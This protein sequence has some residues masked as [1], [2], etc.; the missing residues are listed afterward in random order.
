M[1]TVNESVARW[2]TQLLSLRGEERLPVLLELTWHLRQRDAERALQLAAEARALH[3]AH[4][5]LLAHSAIVRLD[6]VEA[7]LAWLRGELEAA[8]AAADQLLARFSALGDLAGQA[9][10]HWLLAWIA[11]DRGDH[12]RSLAEFV[13]TADCA[14]AAGDPLRTGIAQAANARWE[15][16]RDRVRAKANWGE[17]I[18]ASMAELHPSLA[19]WVYDYLALSASH[20]GDYGGAADA[21]VRCYESALETGQIRAAITAATNIGEDF[22]IVND[23]QSALEWMQC[24]LDLARPTGWPRSVGA[25]LMHTAD[26]LRRLGQFDA[27]HDML[28]E[29]LHVLQPLANARSYAIALQYMGDLKLAM[30]DCAGALAAFEQLEARGH[31]LD[32]ADFRSIAQRGKAQALSRL[33]RTAAALDAAQQAIDLADGQGHSNNHISALRAMASVHSEHPGLPTPPG[34][35]EPNAALHY[36]Q[37]ALAVSRGIDGYTVP[38]DLYDAMGVAYAQVGDYARAYEMAVAASAARVKTHSEEATNRAIAMQVHHQTEAARAESLHHRQLAASEARR[39]ETL[40]RTNTM[41]E[42]LSKI[43]QEI[44]AHLNAEAIFA[45]VERHIN[46]LLPVTTFAI[47]LCDSEGSNTLQRAF[48]IENGQPL[49]ANAIQLNNPLSNSVRALTQRTE[50][51]IDEWPG[52]V[53]APIVPGTAVTESAM[54]APLIVGERAFGVMT[55]QSTEKHAYGETE[56]LIFRSLCAYG[57][58]ALDN[59]QTYQRL[60]D[61]QSQ[62]VAQE[63]LA[64]LGALMAGVAHELNTPIGNSLLIASTLQAKTEDLVKLLAGPGIRK[65]DLTNYVNDAQKAATLVMRGLHSAAHL[66]SSFKQVAV[67]RTT[68]QRRQFNLHQVCHEIVATM[69]NRLRAAKHSITLD[70]PETIVLDSYPGPFGQV[71]TNLINN[72]LLHAFDAREQGRMALMAEAGPEGRVL[73]HF[74]DDGAGIDEAHLGRI[75]DPFFTTKLGRGGSGLGLSISYNIVTG[76]LGGQISVHSQPG[77]GTRFSLDLPLTAPEHEAPAPAIIY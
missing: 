38:G 57:A 9:D 75:F 24:A 8:L 63:K 36:L 4:P 29:A 25:C 48:G 65:S 76:L 27:A 1:F 77:Q 7:E 66:V 73:V 39:A 71:I 15:V 17:R 46:G 19:T 43:G 37:R 49:P 44:T 45:T 54:F 2:E 58:I 22:T 32:Q 55:V 74:E 14:R 13:A 41:L 47:Y 26:T 11:V 51:F 35:R 60:T 28:T 33:G 18:T 52:E 34:M 53:L 40:A 68:E 64:A 30:G 6:L 56:R 59:A 5:A 23:H 16:L 50:I 31:A 42:K 10:T 72:A 62:L 69:M 21:F 12:G 3:A 67:D 61:A 20:E 70:I